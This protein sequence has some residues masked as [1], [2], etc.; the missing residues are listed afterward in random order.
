[1]LKLK[2]IESLLVKYYQ[3]KQGIFNEENQQVVGLLDDIKK[4]KNFMLPATPQ[5]L[6]SPR[7]KIRCI[8]QETQSRPQKPV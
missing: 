2:A 8:S 7:R 3:A 1:M 6:V 5:T 4:N